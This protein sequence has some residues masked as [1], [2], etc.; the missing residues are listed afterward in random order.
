MG[1]QILFMGSKPPAG[2]TDPLF[3]NVSSL[4]H[5]DDASATTFTDQTSGAQTRSG[6]AVNSTTQS[7]FGGSSLKI[8]ALADCINLSQTID[9][10]TKWVLEAST[11]VTANFS[12]DY[13]NL[14]TNNANTAQNRFVLDYGISGGN[15]TVRIVT[16]GNTVVFSSTPTA[17]SLNSWI[18]I[19]AENDNAANTCKLFVNGVVVGS[20]SAINLG[21]LSNVNV[22]KCS[23]NWTGS[24]YYIDEARITTLATRY[25]GTTY[26]PATATFPNF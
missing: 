26:T 10:R 20:R 13:N 14:F 19:A 22:G 1:P 9:L 6:A 5:F 11:Y 2:I 25:G 7:K 15:I 12:G 4:M 24:P 18:D 3:A 23:A 16:N 21:L 8:S 17:A